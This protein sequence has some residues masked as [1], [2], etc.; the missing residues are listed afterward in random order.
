MPPPLKVALVGGPMYDAL[1]AQRLPAFTAATGIPVEIGAQLIHPELNAHLAAAYANGDGGY[2]LITTHT[3]YAPSQADWLLPLDDLLPDDAL[4]DFAPATV[5]LARVDGRLLGV[6]RNVDTRLLHYR[7]DLFDDPGEQRAFRQRFG[8]D[9]APPA[10]WEAFADIARHFAR[11]PD[12]YGFAFPGQESGLWGAFFELLAAAGGQMFGPDLRPA[13]VTPQGAWA[14]GLLR[15][16]VVTWQA[17]PPETPDWQFDAVSRAFQEGRAAMIADWPGTYAS[18]AVSP[19]GERFDVALYPAGPAGRHVYSGGFTWAIPADAADPAASLS[20]LLYLAS[21][22]S[23]GT[24]AARGVL[25]PRCA[26]RQATREEAEPGSREAR[27][28]ALLEETMATSMLVPP[29]FAA[30]PAVEAALWPALQWGMT[31]EIPVDEA[32]REAARRMDEVLAS[33]DEGGQYRD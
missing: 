2:D 8:Y 28:L 22:E 10:T 6:P 26:T 1:Y 9:L 32:L 27:R 13:F 11:P 30:Y 21:P 18:H 3:K 16:L 5:D 14:L 19:V 29:R 17:A 12:L 25:V 31:G 24:E 7:A 15:D 4:A 33:T 23:Q 20:L